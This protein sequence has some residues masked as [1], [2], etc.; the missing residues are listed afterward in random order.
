M[1]RRKGYWITTKFK[2]DG[3]I[4]GKCN[5][6]GFLHDMYKVTEGFKVEIDMNKVWNF[7]P[8]CGRKMRGYTTEIQTFNFPF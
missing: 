7:C 5:H 1:F 6:C 4:Y 3:A 8:R 2:G